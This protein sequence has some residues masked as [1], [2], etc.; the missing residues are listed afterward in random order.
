MIENI[1]TK[2][3]HIIKWRLSLIKMMFETE[4][5]ECYDCKQTKRVLLMTGRC[6]PCQRQKDKTD[7]EE[8]SEWNKK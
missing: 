1:F 8:N 4:I 5:E 2:S 3:Y 7:N 6:I